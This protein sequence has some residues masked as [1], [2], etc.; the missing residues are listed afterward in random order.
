[1]L[2]CRESSARSRPPLLADPENWY[3]DG[4]NLRVASQYCQVHARPQRPVDAVL[5]EV[6]APA[7]AG[8]PHRGGQVVL[9][10]VVVPRPARRGSGASACAPCLSTAA[11]ASAT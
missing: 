8:V 10:L 11:I 9:Q 3:S 2:A 5:V 4:L 1:M 6:P 7:T